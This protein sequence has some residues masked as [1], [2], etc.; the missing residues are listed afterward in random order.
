MLGMQRTLGL[1]DLYPEPERL[2][3]G[4]LLHVLL[5]DPAQPMVEQ[6]AVLDAAV[7]AAA[8][9]GWLDTEAWGRLRA[10]DDA[11]VLSILDEVVLAQIFDRAGYDLI[12]HP[13]GSAGKVGELLV[14]RGD[15][16]MFVEVKS[17]LPAEASVL[18]QTTLV[19]LRDLARSL[20]L[21]ACLT[22]EIDHHPGSGINHKE[23]RRYLHVS[24]EQLLQ[25]GSPPAAYTHT[26]GLYLRAISCVPADVPHL[27]VEQ[28]I[29]DWPGQI[30]HRRR[31]WRD[32]LWRAL[33][34]GY[35]QLPHDGPP[36]L[37]IVVDHS[38]PAPAAR[39]W[40]PPLQDM[41]R[42]G[43]HRH[44]SAVGRVTLPGLHRE[45]PDLIWLHNPNAVTPLPPHPVISP[46]ETHVSVLPP[47][48]V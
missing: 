44:L 15:L 26:S 16:A 25:G 18:M 40:L 17:L 35:A 2:R 28:N 38:E 6:R 43:L 19:R 1:T 10:G 30:G 29:E 37:I 21:A 7:R 9:R 3:L 24:A 33:R 5:T 46:G 13:P 45:P 12:F 22:V 8:E 31:L 23:V 11:G 32:R 4:S 27:M 47:E 39:Y 48:Q 42:M 20:P 41:L 14:R 34:G 36:A